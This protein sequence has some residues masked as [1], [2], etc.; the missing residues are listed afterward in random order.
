MLVA[1]RRSRRASRPSTPC[2][3]PSSTR[4]TNKASSTALVVAAVSIAAALI[5][6]QAPGLQ[7][8]SATSIAA[9]AGDSQS[10][11][12]EERCRPFSDIYED[13]KALCE[14]IFSDSFEYVPTSD[15]RHELAYTMWDVSLTNPNDA[16]TRRRLERGL[17]RSPTS[18][19][20]E[21]APPERCFLQALH[22]PVPGPEL[23]PL[24]Y[25]FQSAACCAASTVRD[26]SALNG[27]Y[28]ASYRWDRCGKLSLSCESFF[29]QEACLYECDRNA[30]LYRK[31]PLDTFNESDPDQNAWQ[32][33]K[34]PIKGEY[35]DAWFEACKDD[36]FCSAAGGDF[37]SC[38]KIASQASNEA[39]REASS[40]LPSGVV[41]GI[42]V[43]ATVLVGVAT[44]LVFVVRR[45]RMGRPVFARL[46]MTEARP[47]QL[48]SGSARE[49]R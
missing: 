32:M 9:A 23:A 13:G 17:V 40:N 14:R 1:R 35:C 6:A 49:L 47:V 11:L 38:A 36:A 31:F 25:P 48:A 46:S 43:A 15:P 20:S 26:P 42:A 44:F 30:G 21:Q 28:G 10:A 27:A 19:S 37:F 16:V 3:D 4:A 5:K 2:A 34:M 22:K 33:H 45:E 24:C 8:C 29:I 7:R 41:A 12:A 18:Q 39:A